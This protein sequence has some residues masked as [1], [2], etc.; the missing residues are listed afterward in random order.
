MVWRYHADVTYRGGSWSIYIRELDE[1]VTAS[2]RGEIAS[3]ALDFILA[4]PGAVD[5]EIDLRFCSERDDI[6]MRA[7]RL[8]FG[9]IVQTGGR[10]DTYQPPTKRKSISV[11]YDRHGVVIGID[12]SASNCEFKVSRDGA[13]EALFATAQYADTGR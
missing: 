10:V 1:T 8:G 6:R 12:A 9:R 13:L 11:E 4:R 3:R 2:H 7:A 5:A